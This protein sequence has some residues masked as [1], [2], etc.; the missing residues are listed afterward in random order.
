[1]ARGFWNHVS[2]IVRCIQDFKGQQRAQ[3]IYQVL[4]TVCTVVGFLISCVTRQFLYTG[5]AAAGS[6]VLAMLVNSTQL[7]VPPWPW[8]NSSPVVW[9]HEKKKKQ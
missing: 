4:I 3:L 6:T 7:V 9:A 2:E 8:Y 1:M 5:Y